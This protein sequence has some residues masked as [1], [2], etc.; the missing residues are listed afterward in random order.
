MKDDLDSKIFWR[1]LGLEDKKGWSDDE[2]DDDEDY[3]EEEEEEGEELEVEGG[4]GVEGEEGYTTK[5]SSKFDPFVGLSKAE[6]KRLV[7]DQKKEKRKVKIPK[8]KKK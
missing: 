7:K 1:F 6:R 8:K 2:E 4:E 5:K 3:D